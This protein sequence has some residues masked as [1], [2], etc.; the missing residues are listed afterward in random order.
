MR[1]N[2]FNAKKTYV[3]GIKFD[4]KKEALRFIALRHQQNNGEISNLKLQPRFRLQDGFDFEGERVRPI[5]Y[6]ADFIY[7]RDGETIVEETK[8]CKTED[9]KLRIKLF[10]RNKLDGKYFDFKFIET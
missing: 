6:K 5:N 2:K 3:D 9:Y 10:K 8:G 1:K 7:I 4:S